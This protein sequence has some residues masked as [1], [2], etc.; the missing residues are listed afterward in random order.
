MAKMGRPKVA[1]PKT[2]RFSV[3]MDVETH[4]ALVAYCAAH[5]L[6]KGAALRCGLE[7][8]FQQ[9]NGTGRADSADKK[10]CVN[11]GKKGG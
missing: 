3:R 1:N 4:R 11:D 5:G 8:L 6:K 2:I 9:D 10:G 7:L